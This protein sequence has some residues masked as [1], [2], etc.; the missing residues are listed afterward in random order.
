MPMKQ[1][2]SPTAKSSKSSRTNKN[3]GK[4]AASVCVLEELVEDCDSKYTFPPYFL[5][6]F[7]HFSLPD[8]PP[9]PISISFAASKPRH[10]RG[11]SLSLSTVGD[12]FVPKPYVDVPSFKAYKY[13]IGDSSVGQLFNSFQE[14]SSNIVNNL[15]TIVYLN[16]IS[17]FLYA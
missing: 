5:S 14:K 1:A 15:D 17:K 3:E 2:K 9:L 11:R 8:T 4:N 6:V 12:D 16:N 10:D 7:T 13:L